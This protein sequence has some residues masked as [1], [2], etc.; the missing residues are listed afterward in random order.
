MRQLDHLV[1]SDD[2]RRVACDNCEWQGLA[3]ETHGIERLA[4][5]IAP[6]ETV[7]AGE[8]PKCGALAHLSQ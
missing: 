2:Q 1:S 5:R 6:G 4:E 7:P 8:C 3:N